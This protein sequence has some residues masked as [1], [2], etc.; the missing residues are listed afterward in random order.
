MN[1]GMAV[2]LLDLMCIPT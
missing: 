2:I 1:Q